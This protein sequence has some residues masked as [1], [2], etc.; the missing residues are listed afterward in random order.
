MRRLVA[1]MLLSLVGC[2]SIQKLAVKGV[3]PIFV[4]GSDKLTYERNWE[5]FKE[6]SPSNIQLVE[7]LYLQ[8]PENLPLLTTLIKTYAGYTYA[9]PETLAFGDEL[10]GVEGSIHKQNAIS[11]YTKTLDYGLSYFL[12]KGITKNDLLTLDAKKLS[13]KIKEKLS[14]KDLT[15]VLFTAQAWLSLINLQ[16]DNVALITQIPRAKIV[17][18]WVCGED[19]DIE[20]GV[21]DMF[22]AQYEGSRPKMLGGNPEKAKE[23]YSAAMKKRP[24]HLLIR[25]GYIQYL[26]LPGFDEEAYAYESKI[27]KEEF[28]KW[29]EI[30]RDTLVDTSE[31]KSVSHLNLFNAIAMKRFEI[32]EQNKKKLFG[33]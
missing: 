11:Y 1:L 31:Y 4:E 24:K 13:K 23:L 8:D 9:V 20:N 28:A 6:A 32:I 5:F 19:K 30:N 25:V 29:S 17:I 21:C 27:L 18:D 26:V 10:S 15:A 3:T 14:K 16:K 22:Y 2:S 33:E 7:M 12:M